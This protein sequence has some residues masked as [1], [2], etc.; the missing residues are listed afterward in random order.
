MMSGVLSLSRCLVSIIMLMMSLLSSSTLSDLIVI[1]LKFPLN[2]EKKMIEPSFQS[3]LDLCDHH[4]REK[5]WTE[6]DILDHFDHFLGLFQSVHDDDNENI[7]GGE[8]NTIL[9][10]LVKLL[11]KYND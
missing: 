6:I 2:P 5:T 11:N 7:K 1:E 10:T 9:T 4:L 8:D 3:S